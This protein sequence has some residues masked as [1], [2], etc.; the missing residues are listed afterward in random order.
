MHEMVGNCFSVSSQ[1]SENPRSGDGGNIHFLLSAE[2]LTLLSSVRLARVTIESLTVP[3]G[4]SPTTPRKTSNKG[5]P[6]RPLIAKKWLGKHL[7]S[8]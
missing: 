6:P 4:S 1:N 2:Q 7:K 3:A 5:K 8:C